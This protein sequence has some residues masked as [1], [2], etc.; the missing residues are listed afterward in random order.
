[1]TAKQ[2]SMAAKNL[3]IFFSMKTLHDKLVKKRQMANS[4]NCSK[5][6]MKFVVYVMEIFNF[7]LI[8]YYL[9]IYN[10]LL[11]TY[12]GGLQLP[13]LASAEIVSSLLSS[14]HIVFC[15]TSLI[16]LF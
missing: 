16:E 14:R 12:R 4:P 15:G 6:E 2:L 9:F 11:S 5:V 1:M 3:F 7:L 10:K 8:D 13:A